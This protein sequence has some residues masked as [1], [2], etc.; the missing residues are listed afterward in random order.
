[1]NWGACPCAKRGMKQG[2]APREERQLL[3]WH[4]GGSLPV[5]GMSVCVES[6][7]GMLLPNSAH[8]SNK[9]SSI[10]VQWLC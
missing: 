1:M 5:V 7:N 6:M 10:P 9:Y 8:L 4:K 2:K 3:R